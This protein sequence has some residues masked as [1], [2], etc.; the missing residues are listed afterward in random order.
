MLGLSLVALCVL[1]CTDQECVILRLIVLVDVRCI[2]EMLTLN[3]TILLGNK[4][5]A[6]LTL[7]FAMFA[8][9]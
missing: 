9:Q 3:A 2:Q 8:F 1:H 4:S 5:I 6:P 7:L